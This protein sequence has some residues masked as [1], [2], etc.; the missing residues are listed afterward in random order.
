MENKVPE[1]SFQFLAIAMALAAFLPALVYSY[2]KELVDELEQTFTE[3]KKPNSKK[4]K[5]FDSIKE[6]ITRFVF[7]ID[8]ILTQSMIL[9]A[10]SGLIGIIIYLSSFMIEYWLAFGIA[11]IVIMFI[12]IGSLIWSWR[13]INLY[14]ATFNLHWKGKYIKDLNGKSKWLFGWKFYRTL[15]VILTGLLSTIILI[16]AMYYTYI[17]QNNSFLCAEQIKDLYFKKGYVPLNIILSVLTLSL[18]MAAISWLI[19]LIHYTPLMGRLDF[20]LDEIQTYLK[21]K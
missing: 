16:C 3:F 12:Y 2:V 20:I 6:N 17:Q 7:A 11:L 9:V 8:M 19:P 13:K 14:Q 10:F 4:K 18:I 1:I 15:W 21:K 5:K